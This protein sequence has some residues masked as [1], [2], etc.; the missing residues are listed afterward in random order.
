[1]KDK[2]L[3]NK[4]KRGCD[5]KSLKVMR[6]IYCLII[7]ILTVVIYIVAVEHYGIGAILISLLFAIIFGIIPYFQFDSILKLI[8]KS[9]N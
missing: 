4:D 9:K 1:M 2:K 6:N 5:M 7:G 8:N 3:H